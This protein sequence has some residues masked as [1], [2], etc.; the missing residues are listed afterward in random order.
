[1]RFDE[2]SAVE[3]AANLLSSVVAVVMALEG[4]AYWALV[5]KPALTNAFSRHAGR[6][7]GPSLR[8]RHPALVRTTA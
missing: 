1:M 7:C 6:A 2:I 5:L 4:F 3:I 8:E